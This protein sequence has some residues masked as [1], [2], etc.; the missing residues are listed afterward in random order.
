METREHETMAAGATRA[1]AAR[2]AAARRGC[3]CGSGDED[4]D[5]GPEDCPPG[6]PCAPCC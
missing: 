2:E 5:C 3:G 1:E 4:D 6:C